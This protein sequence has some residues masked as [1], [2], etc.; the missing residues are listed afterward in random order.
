MTFRDVLAYGT[1]P[2][3]MAGSVGGA[4]WGIEAGYDPGTWAFAVSVV[5]FNLV[6]LLD[7]SGSMRSPNKLPLLKRGMKML[8]DQL[9]KMIESQSWSTLRRPGWYSIRQP[10]MKKKRS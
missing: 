9:G 8:V 5:N 1:W 4:I 7:V 6:F 2:L 3:V 10:P